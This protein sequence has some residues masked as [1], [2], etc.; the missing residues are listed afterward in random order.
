[1]VT[2]EINSIKHLLKLNIINHDPDDPFKAFVINHTQFFKHSKL[3]KKIKDT[4][5]FLTWKTNEY[6]DSFTNRDLGII[7]NLEYGRFTEL[8]TR[9]CGYSKL[10]MKKYAEFLW[11]HNMDKQF[12][13]DG[14]NDAPRVSCTKLVFPFNTSRKV[15]TQVLSFFYPNNLMNEFLY[16]YDKQKFP[17]P[18]CVCEK[19]EQ[20][21]KHLLTTCP[22][23]KANIRTV[24]SNILDGDPLHHLSD[25]GTNMFLVSWSRTPEFFMQLVNIVNDLEDII[26][27]EV[28]L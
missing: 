5:A 21:S 2:D 12:Q 28:V 15:E 10:V 7:E 9:A 18:L 6:E 24:M 17:S 3:T 23:V 11:Q 27:F 22:Y 14:Y 8:S 16:R 19:E 25:Y 13:L 26:R 4:F 20:N 1:M